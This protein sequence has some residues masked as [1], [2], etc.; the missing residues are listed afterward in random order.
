[1]IH[2]CGYLQTLEVF[3]LEPTRIHFIRSI[4]KKIGLAQTSV[5]NHIKFLLENKIILK[6]QSSPFNGYVANREDENFIFY[7][8]I[9]NLSSLKNLKDFMINSCYPKAVILFG[10]Y[11]R[12]EDIEES[13]IDLFVL[14]KNKRELDIKKFEGDLK[15]RINILFCDSLNKLDEKIQNKIRNGFV[16]EGEL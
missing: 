5:R 15:R 9:Y 4:S 10:S 12:G 1:M 13:D 8:S 3:F 11:L 16:L 2:K 7:K 14:S 6:K